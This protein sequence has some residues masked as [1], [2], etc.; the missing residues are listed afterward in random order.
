VDDV[1]V[2]G[3]GRLFDPFRPTIQPDGFASPRE[4]GLDRAQHF[5]TVRMG[6][7]TI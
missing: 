7:G 4:Y 1:W 5:A 2:D 6:G 3:R